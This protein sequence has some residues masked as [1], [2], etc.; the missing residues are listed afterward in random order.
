[1]PMVARFSAVHGDGSAG[2]EADYRQGVI[3]KKPYGLDDVRA[4]IASCLGSPS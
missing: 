1:M 3:I 4:A 2:I